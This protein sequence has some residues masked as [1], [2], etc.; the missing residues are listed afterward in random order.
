MAPHR[1]N[2]RG[3]E[4]VGLLDHCGIVKYKYPKRGSWIVVSEEWKGRLR[5]LWSDSLRKDFSAVSEE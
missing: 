2:S 1:E 5:R 3:V 4:Y